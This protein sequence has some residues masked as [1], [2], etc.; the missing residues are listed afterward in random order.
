MKILLDTCVFLWIISGDRELSEKRGKI[1]S[2]P[3][4]E[5]F[6]SPISV[7]EIIVKHQIGRLPLPE[8]PETFVL[9]NRKKHGIE[10]L[11]LGEEAALQLSKL[12]DYHKDPFD[13][14][15]VCQA[16]SEGMPVMTPDPSINQY[17]VR[18]IW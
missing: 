6:L 16:I 18:T 12:P 9:K 15:L 11:P 5:I 2:S 4:N 7:W 1:F 10:S 8:R 17:P 14:M 13:R 3:D